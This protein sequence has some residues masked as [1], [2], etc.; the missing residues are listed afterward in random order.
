MEEQLLKVK[1]ED[2]VNEHLMAAL[3]GAEIPLEKI[4]HP[5]LR[6]VWRKYTCIEG[7]LR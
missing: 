4:D 7:S 6:G 2:L 1:T 5:S 3:L